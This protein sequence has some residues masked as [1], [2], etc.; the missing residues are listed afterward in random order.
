MTSRPEAPGWAAPTGVAGA[1]RWGTAL[2]VVGTVAVA[3][4]SFLPWAR[5]GRA[6]RDS[7]ELVRAAERLDIVTGTAATLAEG[8]YLVALVAVA[9][10]AGAIFERPLFVV[11]LSLAVATAAVS[12]VVA[13]RASPLT[14]EVGSGVALVSAGVAAAGVPVAAWERR[15]RHR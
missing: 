10:C 13:V 3:V 7:Y 4:A 1:P 11:I 14:L 6:S 9:A 12:L 5:S 15:S 2:S 8:W